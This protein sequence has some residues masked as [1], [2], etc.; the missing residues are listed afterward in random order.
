MFNRAPKKITDTKAEMAQNLLFFIGVIIGFVA[1]GAF[2]KGEYL[3]MLICGGL[4]IGAFRWGASIKTT[5]EP[6]SQTTRYTKR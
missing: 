4:S 5:Y 1:F 6:E 3:G 2:T